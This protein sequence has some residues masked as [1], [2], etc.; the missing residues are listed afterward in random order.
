MGIKGLAKLL[1]DEAPDSLREVPL[2]SLQGRKIA[3]D[4]SMA[5]Y[6]FLIAVRSGGPGGAAMMLTNA[7]GETTSHIQGLFNRTIRF[8][9][10][11]I[12]PAYVFDGKP[13]QFKSHELVKR[14]EKRQKAE[15]ALKAAEES[16]N[17]EEQDK[18]NK[19]LVR[20]GTKENNDCK[21]L[22]RLMGVPVIEAPCEAEA[23]AAAL[24]EAGK[25]YATAT[26][27]MDALTFRTPIQIRK[28]TFANAS[29]AEVQQISYAKAIEGLGIT[30][31]QF[32][33]LCILLG[34]DYCDTIRGIGPKTALKLIREHK[35]IETILDVIDRDKY[36]VPETYEPMEARKRKMEEDKKKA[37]KEAD[38]DDEEDDAAKEEK[39]EDDDEE[40]LIPVFVEARRLFNQHEVLPSNEIELKWTECQPEPLKS[41][42]V[43]DM[44][45]NP[46]RVQSSIEKLQ[47]AFKK[48]TKPQA[49][50]DMFFK[51]KANPEADKKRAAKRK[52]EKDA[53]KAKKKKGKAG[54]KKK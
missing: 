1:S 10:E 23:Q 14:R 48:S 52:A 36:V 38:T 24:A 18:Q 34:C 26:E 13:P 51:V 43:D 20:A 32:V 44:G 40:E 35:N 15:E 4:A 6:Q 7:D 50:M 17:I 8:I 16:G 45:F 19:R 21:K 22:L 12:R 46:D 28:M 29:K 37:A 33:D 25:V 27:D 54:G 39:K 9:T 47:K 11:G 41:F 49:R 53:E 42:L 2:S 31:E 3:V 30:H 5:I